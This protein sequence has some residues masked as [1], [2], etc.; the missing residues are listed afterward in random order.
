MKS[1]LI[2]LNY[3]SYVMG[4]ISLS[5]LQWI[6]CK[7]FFFFFNLAN[8]AEVIAIA[9]YGP[10]QEV[11]SKSFPCPSWLNL[12]SL[13]I[14]H[15]SIDKADLIASGWGCRRRWSDFNFLWNLLIMLFSGLAGHHW[16]KSMPTFHGYSFK[17]QERHREA[18]KCFCHIG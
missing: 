6:T 14:K 13:Y 9:N 5:S 11:I 7:V 3:D 17:I 15:R 10:N 4:P 2:K 8:I 12:T 18:Q 1:S 16:R